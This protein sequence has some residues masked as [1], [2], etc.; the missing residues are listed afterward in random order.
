VFAPEDAD[1][2]PQLPLRWNRSGSKAECCQQP[3]FESRESKEADWRG[4]LQS[5]LFRVSF[6]GLF[7]VGYASR[8]ELH[9]ARALRVTTC[10]SPSQDIEHCL[11][12]REK[13][14]QRYR[15]AG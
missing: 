11:M 7:H 4:R 6:P 2:H 10:S 1:R 5:R 3:A 15:L 14:A 9:R 12:N 13:A 8:D